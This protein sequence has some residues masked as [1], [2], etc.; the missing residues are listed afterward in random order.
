[1][2]S[3]NTEDKLKQENENKESNQKA[4]VIKNTTNETNNSPVT[5]SLLTYKDL[6]TLD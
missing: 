4:R 2:L 6:I 1:M 3:N 5:L